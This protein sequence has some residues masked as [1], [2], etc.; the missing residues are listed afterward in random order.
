G[1]PTALSLTFLGTLNELNDPQR[2]DFILLLTDGLPNCNPNNAKNCNVGMCT[3]T[4]NPTTACAPGQPFCTLGCLDDDGSVQAIRDLRDATKHA[5]GIRTIVV[6]FGSDTASGGD[7]L[8]AMAV[9]GGFQ[10]TCPSGNDSECGSSNT[11][12]PTKVCA[13]A[14]YQAA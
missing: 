4:L 5:G 12:L 2:E 14:Y 8:N 9:A 7:V 1:T 6:G 3:C 10:R 13:K 11:C